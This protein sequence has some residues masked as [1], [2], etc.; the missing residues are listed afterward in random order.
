MGVQ[1]L[2]T[3]SFLPECVVSNEDL[4]L[5]GCD[6]E[7][8]VRRTGIVQRRHV[9]PG[10]ATADLAVE[11]GLRCLER[12][13]VRPAEVDLLL[14]GTYTPDYLL[15][16]T[17]C[18]VQDRLAIRAP[19]MDIQAACAS[20]MFGLL[21]G[22]QFVA[23]GCCRR[24]LVIGADCNSR[25]VNPADKQTFP[26][27]GDGAGAALLG[28]G[29]AD[30]GMAAYAFGSDGSGADVLYR[31]MGGTAVPYSADAAADGQHYLQMEG[32][33]VFKWAI[34]LVIDTVRQV[35]RLARI[36]ANDLA[37]VVLHQANRRIIA[38]AAKELGIPD[39]KIVV[40]VDRV[41][42]TA[43]ASVPLA[44]DEAY[45]QDRIQPGD[46]VLM[47]GFGAGLSWGTAVFRW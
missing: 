3:G 18:L 37:L 20:F 12:A 24:V 42:N 28:P 16:S 5:L 43:A 45:Q 36:T 6:P 33:A 7:W 26:L 39:H 29:N 46:Y 31:R 9:S 10:Q 40:N 15:P 1:I 35:L 13:G 14:V 41:G 17:A 44:L 2:A 32:R 21:S 25:V 4:A 38:A 47:S 27:F 8:I 30:Q 11:A 19:A 22:M 23:T 34:R